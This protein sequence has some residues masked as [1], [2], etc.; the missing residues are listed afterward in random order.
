M[1]KILLGILIF[2]VFLVGCVQSNDNDKMSENFKL[3]S[4]NSDCIVDRG[5]C[6]GCGR[7]GIATAINKN[8]SEEWHKI[9]GN[10]MC[11]SVES[12]DPTCKA[13]PKCVNGKC[14]LVNG[15]FIYE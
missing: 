8:F 15:I 9:L 14:V 6:C 1:R 4:D 12:N 10:C 3:C 2:L 11:P 13:E 7:G 5:N